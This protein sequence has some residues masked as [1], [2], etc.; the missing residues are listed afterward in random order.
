M[1]LFQYAFFCGFMEFNQVKSN[2]YPGYNEKLIKKDNFMSVS[3][4]VD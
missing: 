4:M 1:R 3:S 2:P